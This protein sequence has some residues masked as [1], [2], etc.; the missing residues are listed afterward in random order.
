[1]SPEH[2][3]R[4][5]EIDATLRRKNNRWLAHDLVDVPVGSSI[6]FPVS[7]CILGVVSNERDVIFP[8]FF[9]KDEMPVTKKKGIYTLTFKTSFVISK[10]FDNKYLLLLLTE[11]GAI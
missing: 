3:E 9:K 4:S 5:H 2:V 10:L 8:Y 7:V 1:L 6:K 11:I